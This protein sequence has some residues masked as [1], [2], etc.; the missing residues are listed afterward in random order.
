[1]A[2]ILI[3]T[4]GITS[5]VNSSIGM[6]LR[7]EADGH[8]IS[9]GSFANIEPTVISAKLPFLRLPNLQKLTENPTTNAAD[10]KSALACFPALFGDKKYDLAIIDIECHEFIVSSPMFSDKLILLSTFLSLWRRPGLI[11]LHLSTQPDSYGPRPNIAFSFIWL[12]YVS[13]KILRNR[14]NKLKKFGRDRISNLEKLSSYSKFPWK[15]KRDETQWLKPI[16]YKNL[17][18]LNLNDPQLDYP[19]IPNTDAIYV[20]PMRNI[21]KAEGL[22]IFN[23]TEKTRLQTILNRNKSSD[24][25]PII[26]CSFGRFKKSY[27][28]SFIQKILDTA[29]LQP[30]WDF[31]ISLGGHK[32]SAPFKEVPD[33]ASLFQW[34]PQTT[35]LQHVDCA[36]VHSGISS[37]NECIFARVPMVLYSLGIRDQEG[38]ASRVA[39]HKLGVIG[40]RNR[41]SCK[42]IESNILSAIQNKE[43]TQALSKY[44]QR[45]IQFQT[46][47]TLEKAVNHILRS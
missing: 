7:L 33:N 4:S 36:I 6:A 25:R 15:K 17:S 41:D 18:V 30:D 16:F 21:D 34:L 44:N 10:L 31:L 14:L 47:Q 29:T 23:N 19:H 46:N 45:A 11:P 35:V 28:D 9:Y 39:F 43:I 40:D 20:G 12:R 8:R 24:H 37:I 1:M 5:V 38:N 26:Y 3:I 42:E 22:A 27:D 32:P 13:S 2:R